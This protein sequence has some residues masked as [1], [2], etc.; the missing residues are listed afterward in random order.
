MANLA[1]NEEPQETCKFAQCPC[2]AFKRT[3][4]LQTH[5]FHPLKITGRHHP[6]N[7]SLQ[8][9]VSLGSFL[10]SPII[11]RSHSSVAVR[12]SEGEVVIF[13]YFHDIY[14]DFHDIYPVDLW[15]LSNLL[16][17]SKGSVLC[18]N[19]ATNLLAATWVSHSCGKPIPTIPTIP[20]TSNHLNTKG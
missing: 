3:D 2:F 19:L 12:E 5:W 7:L 18:S 20:T 1:T 17:F 11:P 16:L 15:T 6:S 14:P 13:I 10:E 8:N 4:L 9:Q